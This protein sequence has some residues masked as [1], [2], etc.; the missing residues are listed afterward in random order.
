MKQEIRN[1]V[2]A[3]E[4][5]VLILKK[6][7]EIQKVLLSSG[8]YST[9]NME[10]QNIQFDKVNVPQWERDIISKMWDA[11]TKLSH[12]L[13]KDTENTIDSILKDLMKRKQ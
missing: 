11:Q 10:K 9:S 1:K 8:A 5:E 3:L 4:N 6:L 13:L 12:K 2:Y 7:R